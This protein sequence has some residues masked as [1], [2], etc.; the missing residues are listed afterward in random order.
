MNL[1]FHGM[2]LPWKEEKIMQ[3][4][5]GGGER[6]EYNFQLP[7]DQEPGIYWY[8]N[9]AAGTAAYSYL[10]SLMG[11][12]VVEGNDAT[13]NIAMAPGVEDATEIFMMLSEGLVNPDGSVPPVFPIVMQFN[14][15][16]VV[17]GHLPEATTYDFEQGEKALFHANH[18]GVEPYIYL[19]IP[20]HKMIV[21]GLDGMPVPSPMEVEEIQLHGGQRVDFLVQFDTPGTF[22]MTRAPWNA[23]P[24]T[25]DFCL[26]NFGIPFAPC[27]SY[28]VERD[29]LT[30]NV[31][32]STTPMTKQ[33][34]TTDSITLPEYSDR[35]KALAEQPS[36]AT[37]DLLMQQDVDAYPLFQIPF[38]PDLDIGGFPTGFGF[39]G[40]FWNP[41][42]VQGTVQA[43][44]CETWTVS[45]FPPGTYH[46][47]HSHT[48]DFL[49]LEKDGVAVDEPYWRDT[50]TFFG[51]MKIHICF[52]KVEP[53][54]MVM[55]HCH[56]PIHS[57]VGMM[58]QFE[59]IEGPTPAPVPQ[60]G[61]G[62]GPEPS[63]SS[64][65]PDDG[66]AAIMAFESTVGAFV[67]LIIAAFLY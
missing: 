27:I 62:P 25:D 66:A 57:D 22:I 19:S 54:D 40:R 17:N 35:L 39:N 13:N 41:F 26:E 30:I 58:T 34:L 1:H 11:F 61:P 60:P 59:V 28:A 9:H 44:T 20:G 14:W 67:T 56:M 4:L 31:A 36:V 7:E 12:I 6:R 65:D 43:G 18:A 63:G 47:F 46:P 24:S 16:S 64:D 15:T 8:H 29:V 45:S 42:Y 23:L 52:D 5:D 32:E 53:G 10:A 48:A 33:A 55:V 38:S 49:V 50:E 37:K 3:A 2:S 51:T 21:V